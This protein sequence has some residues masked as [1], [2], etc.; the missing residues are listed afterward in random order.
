MPHLLKNYEFWC[1]W[2]NTDFTDDYS[3]HFWHTFV[4]AVIW[5]I[6]VSMDSWCLVLWM[7]SVLETKQRVEFFYETLP[8][9]AQVCR[10]FPPLCEDVTTL[11]LQIGR[12]CVSHITCRSNV[13]QHGNLSD[14]LSLVNQCMTFPYLFSILFENGNWEWIWSWLDGQLFVIFL[15]T[16]K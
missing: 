6:K 13:P 14:L 9:L 8:S 4:L 12:V 2:K 11:L 15:F 3:M 10:A 16:Q 5:P 7:V 1:K